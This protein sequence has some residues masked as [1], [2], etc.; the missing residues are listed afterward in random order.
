MFCNKMGDKMKSMLAEIPVYPK[1]VRLHHLCRKYGISACA[2]PI[3]APIAEYNGL[4]CY[5]E[6][7]VKDD[8]MEVIYGREEELQ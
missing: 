3:D 5:A 2:L 8:Y 6:Q 7:K 1:H 4:V